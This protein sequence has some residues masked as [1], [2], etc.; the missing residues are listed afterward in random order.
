MIRIQNKHNNNNNL[1]ISPK[2][3][4]TEFKNYLYKDLNVSSV[5]HFFPSDKK[6]TKIDT[7]TTQ[8]LLKT[9]FTSITCFTSE[10]KS[11]TTL[12]YL[13]N[14]ENENN[15]ITLRAWVESNGDP[16]ISIFYKNKKVPIFLL[17]IETAN[18]DLI[19][20]YIDREVPLFDLYSY[21]NTTLPYW[22]LLFDLDD[23]VAKT[24]VD[25]YVIPHINST[26]EIICI[27]SHFGKLDLF[28]Y[29]IE[30][31]NIPINALISFELPAKNSLVKAPPLYYT[32]IQKQWEICDYLICKGAKIPK[33]ILA[34]T[35]KK[36]FEECEFYYHALINSEILDYLNKKKYF[37]EFEQS[38]LFDLFKTCIIR[39][40]LTQAE[41]ILNNVEYD[42]GYKD[43]EGYTL[44]SY[45]MRSKNQEAVDLFWNYTTDKL[46]YDNEKFLLEIAW[47]NEIA[48]QLL[49][50]NK[51]ISET[52]YRSKY[53]AHIF[54]V[55]LSTEINNRSYP[56]EGFNPDLEFNYYHH[57]HPTARL[58]KDLQAFCQNLT[59]ITKEEQT[60]LHELYD[61]FITQEYYN[62]EKLLNRWKEG[63]IIGFIGGWSKHATYFIIKGNTLIHGNRG[64]RDNFL[65]KKPGAQIFTINKPKA[66]TADLIKKIISR[67][68]QEFI[69]KELLKILELSHI[70]TISFPEQPG[71]FCSYSSLK[72]TLSFG[73]YYL[74]RQTNESITKE[75]A[76]AEANIVHREAIKY[77]QE[78]TLIEE[79]NRLISQP[80]K[81]YDPTLL[82][83]C[84]AKLKRESYAREQLV[85]FLQGKRFDWSKRDAQGKSVFHYIRSLE[86][87]RDIFSIFHPEDQEELIKAL[88]H[89]DQYGW[90]PLIQF[91]NKKKHYHLLEPLINYGADIALSSQDTGN[92]PLHLSINWNTPSIF[93]LLLLKGAD[94]L[95]ENKKGKSSY[96]LAHEKHFGFLKDK[97]SNQVTD[98]NSQFYQFIL[99]NYCTKKKILDWTARGNESQSI[100]HVISD[101]NTF[102]L[103]THFRKL[104]EQPLFLEALNTIDSSNNT[105]LMQAIYAKNETLAE[106]ML[107]QSPDFSMKIGPL[108][109]TPL[110]YAASYNQP[111]VVAQLL[112]L[113]ADPDAKNFSNKTAID[114]STPFITQLLSAWNKKQR[115][116]NWSHRCYNNKS[117]FHLI[118]KT[119]EIKALLKFHLPQDHKDFFEALKTEDEQGLPPITYI[120]YKIEAPLKR[121]QILAEI[122]QLLINEQ[123]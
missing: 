99:S 64:L 89:R 82:L 22:A 36:K 58:S 12:Q 48:E 101:V 59:G 60:E 32:M 23:D 107:Y 61:L 44:L 34:S 50:D 11:I 38:E 52:L 74:I 116:F 83:F 35:N 15:S 57:L 119:S 13:L 81:E 42:S 39:N 80:D 117:L 14:K 112:L 47:T 49:E 21:G 45:A 17:A 4:W 102:N 56:L 20:K 55:S 75:Q 122:Q 43:K 65:Y 97:W 54:G 90:T 87:I 113:G 69:E 86:S 7:Y 78:Q 84:L 27:C 37:A 31:H 103:L 115:K 8:E 26:G 85:A 1:N 51:G 28:K 25:K 66:L 19:Q 92:T 62:T 98:A 120:S 77:H 40:D 41:A 68:K 118:T 2:I 67:V 16:N 18:I 29:F 111:T 53:L 109:S 105:P 123:N 63:K 73:A 121:Q 95:L 96:K 100:F 10:K 94:P 79:I 5:D 93:L 106:A 6:Y 104:D 30:K 33:N 108:K 76:I 9:I 91:M 72:T 46:H 114:Y 110:H 88:N 24:L 3:N 70:Y 71:G